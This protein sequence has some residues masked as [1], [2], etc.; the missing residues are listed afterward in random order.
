M[1]K[2]ILKIVELFD[3][4]NNIYDFNGGK[5]P[6]RDVIFRRHTTMDEGQK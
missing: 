5:L 2:I 1:Q 4:R 3:V 6:T